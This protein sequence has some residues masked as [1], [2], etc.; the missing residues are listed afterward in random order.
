[1][2]WLPSDLQVSRRRPWILPR[3]S[4]DF[5]QRSTRRM[6]RILSLESN[7]VRRRQSFP[8]VALPP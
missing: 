1:M 6:P 2:A 8:N 7:H 4:N 5:S 3:Y